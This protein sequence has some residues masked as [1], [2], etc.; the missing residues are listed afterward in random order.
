V[1]NQVWQLD[2]SD[3]ETIA[4]ETWRIAGCRDNVSKLE[5]RWH[6]SWT[7]NHRDTIEAAEL[8]LA[9]SEVLFGH[10]LVD[11]CPVDVETGE[12]LPVVTL[13][14]DNGGPFRAFRFATF[15]SQR[16]ELRHVRARVKSPGENGSRE[17]GFESLK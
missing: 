12:I 1:P 10:L 15:I 14:T 16:P 2:F 5:P 3:F 9:A 17:R 11:G 13:V 6:I 7:A 8:A 4:G